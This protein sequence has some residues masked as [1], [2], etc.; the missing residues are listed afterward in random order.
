MA[1]KSWSLELYHAF[2]RQGH[3]MMQCFCLMGM[4]ARARLRFAEP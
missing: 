1:S 4:Q 2:A 3:P